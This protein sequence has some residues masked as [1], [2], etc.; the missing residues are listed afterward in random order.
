MVFWMLT[1]GVS[2]ALLVITAAAKP[3]APHMAYAHMLIAA[4]VAIVFALIAIREIRSMVSTGA[5]RPAVA[6]ASARYMGF[7][8]TWGA[9]ALL[10]TYS[11]GILYWNE[12]WHFFL[13]FAAA[14]GLS[15]AFARML[16]RDADAGKEDETI[17]KLARYGGIAQLVG[18]LI[19]VFGLLIDGKMTRFLVERHTDWAGNNIF[20]FGALALAAISGYSLKV[21]GRQ[22]T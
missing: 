6:A 4:V 14:A 9:L 16:Q 22:E 15:L 7:V 10:I 3:S 2:V 1:I 18:M 19:V 21:S 20:F 17:L 13:A 8:W 12:W 5:S 11:I